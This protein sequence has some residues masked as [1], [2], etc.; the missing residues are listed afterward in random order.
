MCKCP[1]RVGHQ[2]LAVGA[3]GS[4]EPPEWV[5]ETQVPSVLAGPSL[6]TLTNIFL[7]DHSNNSVSL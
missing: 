4:C 6:Q 7:S 1:R 3:A 2:T 5:L